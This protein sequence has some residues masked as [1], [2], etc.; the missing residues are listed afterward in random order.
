MSFQIA[1]IVD[2][3]QQGGGAAIL[4]QIIVPWG[5]RIWDITEM[6]FKTVLY[7]STMLLTT[8]LQGGGAAI[9]PQFIVPWGHR[10]WDVTEMLLKTFL[11]LSPMSLTI[12][13]S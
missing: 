2:N 5:H 10:I 3:L 4:P 6:L 8:F 11:Y 12:I 1:H 7:L 9:L 13:Y